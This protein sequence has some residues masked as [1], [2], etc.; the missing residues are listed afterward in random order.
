MSTHRRKIKLWIR[1]HDVYNKFI[2]SIDDAC[3]EFTIS[4]T[5]HKAVIVPVTQLGALRDATTDII[6]PISIKC[7]SGAID[8]GNIESN[9]NVGINSFYQQNYSQELDAFLN[10]G[11]DLSTCSD[12]FELALQTY[13]IFNNTGED[14]FSADRNLKLSVQINQVTLPTTHDWYSLLA[15][16]QFAAD[17]YI[18]VLGDL[19]G[20]KGNPFNTP[21]APIFTK[22]YDITTVNKLD[23]QFYKLVDGDAATDVTTSYTFR[24]RLQSMLVDNQDLIKDRNVIDFGCD[25]GHFTY[26]CLPLGCR[27][28]VGAQILKNNND[29]INHAFEQLHLSEQGQAVE[30]DVY[31]PEQLTSVLINIDTILFAGL[32][33][34]VNHHY[35]LLEQFTNSSATGLIVDVRIPTDLGIDFWLDEKPMLTWRYENQ[36]DELTGFDVKAIDANQTYVGVPNASWIYNA[37][38]SLGWQVRSS[39]VTSRIRLHAPQYSYRGILTAVRGT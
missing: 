32:I 18:R 1:G 15:G 27:S 20:S 21:P 34:H 12:E 14:E 9:F 33:Y 37:L 29:K 31:N 2:V 25:R 6:Q 39:V 5:T 23:K 17:I 11:C 13:D 3:H 10:S 19:V 36:E 35:S 28:V 22:H 8:I 7:I 4:N 16:D 26:P 24:I 38:S 30:C